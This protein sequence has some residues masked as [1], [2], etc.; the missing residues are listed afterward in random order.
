MN[1]SA[2]SVGDIG[3]LLRLAVTAVVYLAL[4]G[5]KEGRALVGERKLFQPFF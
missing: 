1:Q 3:A 4:L 5:R 2:H